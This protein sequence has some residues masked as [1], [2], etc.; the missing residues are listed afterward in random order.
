MP[1]IDIQVVRKQVDTLVNIERQWVDHLSKQDQGSWCE[2]AGFEATRAAKIVQA[3]RTARQLL[4]E[5][6]Q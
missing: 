6:E 1:Q 4:M 5:Y 3:L 2:P